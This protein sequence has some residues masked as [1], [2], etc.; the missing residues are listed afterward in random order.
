VGRFIKAY[1][2]PL[3]LVGA[4]ILGTLGGAL[5]GPSAQVMQ[6][7]GDLFL[8]LMFTLVVPLVFFSISAAVANMESPRQVGRIA[9]RMLAIF[10]VTG[11]LSAILALL[12]VLVFPPAQGL[13]LAIPVAEM[14]EQ[15]SVADQLVRAFTV[16]DFT[17]LLSRR[18]MLALILFSGLFGLSVVL[19]GEKAKPVAAALERVAEVVLKM[20]TLV[21]WYAPIGLGAYFAAL[22]GVQGPQIVGDYLRV[23]AVYYP[24]A[25]LYFGL[26]FS[27]YAWMAAGGRGV[28]ALWRE[29]PTPAATAFACG[30]SAAAIP[31]NLEASRKIGV[32]ADI[33]ELVVPLGATIHMDGSSMSAVL[34][35]AFLFGVFG[36][37][38]Q[39]PEVWAFALLVALLSGVVMSGVPGGGFIGEMLIITLYGFP[40]EALPLLAVLGTV[41]DPPATMVNSAGDS[42]VG[43]L[44][45]RWLHGPGWLEK[46]QEE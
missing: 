44:V 46:V 38:F 25:F 41:I 4:I 33:R 20:T 39:G 1:R 6:P 19:V 43:M 24:L 12:A 11:L 13:R 5:A 37:P 16:P 27:L 3:A 18:N 7:L 34:K 8:N 45:A 22:V 40:P 36:Q 28:R 9:G 15:L 17:D 30:S 10:V 35:I 26:F 21:M 31:A 42:V 29:I 14:P 2:L 32:P 23:V